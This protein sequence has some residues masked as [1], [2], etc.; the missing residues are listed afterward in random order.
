MTIDHR[1]RDAEQVEPNP[2]NIEVLIKEARRHQRRRYF[3]AALAIAVIGAAAALGAVLD[4]G[5][6]APRSHAS[7]TSE[8]AALATAK[9]TCLT[10]AKSM[11]GDAHGTPHLYGAY[12]TTDRL[13][14]N[15]PVKIYPSF[16]FSQ[17]TTT[18]LGGE[19]TANSNGSGWPSFLP[20]G[21]RAYICIFTGK[22]SIRVPGMGSQSYIHHSSVILLTLMRFTITPKRWDGSITQTNSIPRVP[23]PVSY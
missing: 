2:A 6:S 19:Q 1:R 22:F 21:Q 3:A 18:T 9:T 17:L 4:R 5:G 16:P 20:A 7:H 23:V 8:V 12:P 14:A 15:W 11:V 10:E 13:A